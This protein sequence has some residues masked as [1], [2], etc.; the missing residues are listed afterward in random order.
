MRS[1]RRQPCRARLAVGVREIACFTKAARRRSEGHR[2]A[3]STGPVVSPSSGTWPAWNFGRNS[4][5]QW[6]A[7]GAQDLRL[8]VGEPDVIGPAVSIDLNVMA[9]V[10]VAA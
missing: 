6:P 1:Q 4:A 8:D 2:E 7:V 10:I 9:A 3:R 5:P